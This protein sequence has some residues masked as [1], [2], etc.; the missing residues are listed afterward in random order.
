MNS[1]KFRGNRTDMTPE[2]GPASAPILL[3]ED[4]SHDV[5][6]ARHAL[7]RTRL[8]NPLFVVE[9]GSQAVHYLRG[10]GCYA[11][12]RNFPLPGLLLL[13]LRM[14]GMDGFEVL[15]WLDAQPAFDHLPTVMLSISE[16][17]SD[18]RMA[19][20][21][22]AS[23]YRIKPAAIDDF[24]TLLRDLHAL[25]LAKPVTPLTNQGSTQALW[26]FAT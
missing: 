18:A 5:F 19:R 25:W 13:D 22:G 20:E 2:F 4:N 11:D 15:R 14:P 3:A 23:D 9:D 21:F 8:T 10:T 16:R 6:F 7:Q 17:G 26:N 12:R 24:V 1:K